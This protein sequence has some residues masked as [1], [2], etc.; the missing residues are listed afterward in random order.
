M[1]TRLPSRVPSGG[2]SVL[3]F[4]DSNTWGSDAADPDRRFPW[5][6]RWPSVLQ[7]EL[8][9]GWHVVEEGLCGRTSVFDDPLQRYR[10]GLDLLAPLLET[11]APLD[12]VI[13]M[14]GTNDVSYP[15]V[16]A[17]AAADGVGA[18]AH[19]VLRSAWG[20]DG[21][22]PRVLLVCPPPA[23]P[24]GE[25]AAALYAGAEEKSRALPQE[26]ARVAA[27][28]GVDWVDAGELIATSPLDGWHLEAAEHETLGTA[29]AALVRERFAPKP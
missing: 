13:V 17:A 5:G 16:T 3:C 26:L 2:R 9:A 10:S 1:T 18:I 27:R 14:L 19:F 11:H 4:G 22:P 12:L 8:G 20:P 28:L 7:R 21:A 15:H 29:L 25:E 23:G 24:F 6:V